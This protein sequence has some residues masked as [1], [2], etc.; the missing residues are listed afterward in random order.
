MATKPIQVNFVTF[1]K[2][3]P[4][5]SPCKLSGTLVCRRFKRPLCLSYVTAAI[6]KTYQPK[7]TLVENKN[8]TKPD[9]IRNQKL[10][11]YVLVYQIKVK[12]MEV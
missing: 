3:C 12:D 8:N 5:P 4:T 11:F 1:A 7:I 2:S 6:S 9:E 10:F